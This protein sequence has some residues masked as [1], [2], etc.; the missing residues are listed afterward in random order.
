MT[1]EL[2]LVED[3][4]EVQVKTIREKKQYFRKSYVSRKHVRVHT[5]KEVSKLNI[6]NRLSFRAIVIIGVVVV[7]I[8]FLTPF[9]TIACINQLFNID[10]AYLDFWNY[11]AAF[12][13]NILAGGSASASAS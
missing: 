1:I 11:L 10:N 8:I 4:P 13:V 2:T 3:Y 6:P 7:A 5:R 9:L 12:G